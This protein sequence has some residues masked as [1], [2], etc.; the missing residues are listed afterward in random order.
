MLFDVFACAVSMAFVAIFAILVRPLPSRSFLTQ[1]VLPNSVISR[2]V[3]LDTRVAG[4]V[5][6]PAVRPIRERR[7]PPLAVVRSVSLS[8]AIPAPEKPRRNVFSRFVR[9]VFHKMQPAAQPRPA[10]ED[11]NPSR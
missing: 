4:Q 9:G 2:P 1:V 6:A 8:D 10:S 3:L 7:L 11:A 5:E